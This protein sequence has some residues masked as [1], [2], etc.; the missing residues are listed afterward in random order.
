[1][2]KIIVDCFGGDRSPDANIEGA[3]KAI[4]E[5]QDLYLILSGD[6]KII[7]EKIK[8]KEYPKERL[9]ILDAPEVISAGEVPTVAIQEKKN[10]SLMKAVNLLRTD[11]SIGGMVTLGNS[12]AVLV[13]SVLRLGRI[14]G[15]IRPAFAP[16]MPTIG[17]GPVTVCDSGANA[18][19][20]K[21]MLEQFGVM[22]SIY[23]SKLFDLKSP[24]VALLNLG[25]EEDKG[26]PLRKEVHQLLKAHKEINFVGNM[27]SRDLMSGDYDV[28]VADGFAGNVLIKSTEGTG[29]ELLKLLKKTMTK[30]FKNK[31][32]ALLLKKDI[33]GIKDFMD[34]NNYGGAYVLGC[35]KTVVKGHG[36]GKAAHVYN[37]VKQA[38]NLE[39]KEL[40][41]E[42]SKAF[43]EKI[44]E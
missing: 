24:R 43:E 37:C 25:V 5:I 29:L 38:Y 34:Y 33:M 12:G 13:A 14:P 10:S 35:K 22:A 2:I 26:D 3:L 17:G 8:D 21:E 36:G 41:Q 39:K 1:M 31:M 40:R 23:M 4:N 15:V 28:V 11:E 27:E 42:I 6:E 44:S 20:S 7:S 18:E 30:N 16:L 9:E 19:C 32:G